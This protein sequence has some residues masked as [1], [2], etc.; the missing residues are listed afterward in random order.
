MH[1][2][3]ICS[4]ADSFTLQ[5][6]QAKYPVDYSATTTQAFHAQNNRFYVDHAE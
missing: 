5:H 6:R 4:D 2:L 3:Y 1:R